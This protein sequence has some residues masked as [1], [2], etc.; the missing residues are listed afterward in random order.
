MPERGALGP[1]RASR[2]VLAFDFGRR[3]IG[4]AVGEDG[5]G[6]AG[7]LPALRGDTPGADWH[8]I[9][10]LI[11]RWRPQLLLVGKPLALDGSSTWM[12]GL[13]AAFARE[14]SERFALP[15]EQADE[16]LTS[17]EARSELAGQRAQGL[18]RRRVKRADVDSHAAQLLLRGWIEERA[19]AQRRAGHG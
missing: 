19:A 17:R 9:A 8:A 2:T 18:R 11:E 1:S 14:L 5:V 10:A 12:T 7:A 3:R 15:V 6:T 4:V 13:A 16:R